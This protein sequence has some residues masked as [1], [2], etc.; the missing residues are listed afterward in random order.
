[1][2]RVGLT[3]NKGDYNMPELPEVETIR[4]TLK[5]FVEDK[6]I[7]DIE[8]FWPKIIKQPDDIEIFKTQLFG[9]TFKDIKRKGKFLLFCLDDYVLVSHLRMEGKYNVWPKDEPRQKHTHVVFTFTNGEELRYNDVRKFG[10]M[11]L[12]PKGSEFDSNPLKKL[13]PDPFDESF[14]FNYFYEKLKKTTRY[15]KPALLDQSIV[16]GL[17][18]IYVD[19]TLFKSH[20]HPL[21]RANTLTKSEVELIREK[22]IETLN[23]AVQLGGTTIRSYVSTDGD[24]GMFQQELFVYGQTD[25]PCK[26]CHEPIEKLK[27]GGRGTHVCPTCQKK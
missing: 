18:N 8:V 20:I 6:T 25:E 11:H 26:I 4:R 1:M 5:R 22:T 3:R 13:G 7:A 14:T 24:M 27:V 23:E 16:T 21:K 9:Q 12:F 17:G 2:A 19:E 15:I 10:T